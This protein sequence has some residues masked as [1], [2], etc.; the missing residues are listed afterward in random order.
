MTPIHFKQPQF[1]HF[2]LPYASS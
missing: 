1:Q 2:A